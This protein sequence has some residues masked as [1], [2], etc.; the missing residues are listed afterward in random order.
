[1][2]NIKKSNSNFNPIFIGSAILVCASN[3][4]STKL[5]G[6]LLFGSQLYI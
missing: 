1:M 6:A 2:V 5:S 4:V 3:A